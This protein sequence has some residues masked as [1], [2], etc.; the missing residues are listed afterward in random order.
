MTSASA[1][2]A[3]FT[4]IEALI[5]V[6]L[7]TVLVGLVMSVFLAQNRFYTRVAV[8]SQ[9]QENARSVT[10]LIATE[11]RSATRGAV[12]RAEPRRLALRTPVYMGIVCLVQGESAYVYLPLD[13]RPLDPSE[14]GGYGVRRADGTWEYFDRPW[15]AIFDPSGGI[16]AER[17]A[18][19]VGAD[20][21]GVAQDFYRFRE[22][23]SV[24]SPPAQAGT[25]VMLF[26]R[27]EYRFQA[28]TLQPG[29]L[30]LYMGLAGDTLAEFATGMT[31]DARFEYRVDGDSTYRATVTGANLALV[32]AVR[33]VALSTSQGAEGGGVEPYVYGWTVDVPMLNAR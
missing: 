28:S 23:A 22:M 3:G 24:P 12:A 21:A 1:R 15:K 25:P 19:A 32:D 16:G 2:R 9:V 33:V 31:P 7:S 29:V 20:T 13:G 26:R 6:T 17:C 10:E 4:V 8:R 27:R 5:A 30:G 18:E 11:V 14:V